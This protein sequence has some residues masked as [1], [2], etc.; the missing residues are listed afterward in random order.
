MQA[1][2]RSRETGKAFR[3][4][5][6]GIPDDPWFCDNDV[7]RICAGVLNGD[8]KRMKFLFV[9][10]VCSP[11]LLGAGVGDDFHDGNW[12]GYGAGGGYFDL[13]KLNR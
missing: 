7:V 12:L 5:F 4:L 10:N 1:D 9:R 2:A 6:V 13:M 11:S 8:T 3:D